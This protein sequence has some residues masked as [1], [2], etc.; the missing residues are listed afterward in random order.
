MTSIHQPCIVKFAHYCTRTFIWLIFFPQR[1]L[2]NKR[3]AGGETVGVDG[4]E[5]EHFSFSKRAEVGEMIEIGG[6]PVRMGGVGGVGGRSEG[7]RE[8]S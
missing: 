6:K 3:E 4:L 1:Y 2:D 5:M 7:G 8:G